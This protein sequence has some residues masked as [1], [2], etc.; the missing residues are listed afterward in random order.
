MA[1][2]LRTADESGKY[3]KLAKNI[4]NI[5]KEKDKANAIFKTNKY[6]EAI[7]AYSKLLEFDPENKMFNS[8]IVAN[9]ALC[10]IKY[11]T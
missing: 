3:Q 5:E 8:T 1:K 9:R 4:N 7:E 6:D 11:L 10:I 2:L